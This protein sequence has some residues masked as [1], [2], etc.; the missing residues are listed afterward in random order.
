MHARGGA[1]GGWKDGASRR[2]GWMGERRGQERA[3]ESLDHPDTKHPEP[4]SGLPEYFAPSIDGSSSGMPFPHP[5]PVARFTWVATTLVVANKKE[6]GG[7]ARPRGFHTT[8]LALTYQH[9]IVKTLASTKGEARGM[10]A[11]LT[12][13]RED[14][15]SSQFPR[16]WDLARWAMGGFGPHHHPSVVAQPGHIFQRYACLGQNPWVVARFSPFNR[17][18]FWCC[19]RCVSSQEQS[20]T[21]PEHIDAPALP[22][23]PP[24]GLE[25]CVPMPP[26]PIG[27]RPLNLCAVA[28]GCVLR[29][30]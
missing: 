16:G 23:S 1:D 13:T 12:G 25:G 29:V 21:T 17:V 10:R 15:T 4:D 19:L 24:S 28:K 18:V 22:P 8:H 6:T 27:R 3:R 30:R 14:Q 7:T 2:D 11:A 26:P 5:L 9:K 20:G